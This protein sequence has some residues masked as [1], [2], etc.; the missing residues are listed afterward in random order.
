MTTQAAL[1][2]A[3]S[4]SKDSLGFGVQS[5]ALRC[6]AIYCAEALDAELLSGLR[7]SLSPC[8]DVLEGL[9]SRGVLLFGDYA[10]SLILHQIGLRQLSRCLLFA[11]LEHH[12]LGISA[13]C[14]L[15]HS[16][17]LHNLCLHCRRCALLHGLHSRLHHR[18][19][20]GPRLHWESHVQVNEAGS[21]SWVLR[22]DTQAWALSQCHPCQNLSLPLTV[23]AAGLPGNQP[24]SA[25]ASVPG[26]ASSHAAPPS[27]SLEWDSKCCLLV[28]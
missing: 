6:L 17:L 28:A 2:V 15:A 22:A 19:H 13:L 21:L 16:L 20:G 18:L 12:R 9:L 3:L 10:A 23:T 8:R 14:N 27:L 7:H 1:T 11:A 25:P 4:C 5:L 26:I 24:I